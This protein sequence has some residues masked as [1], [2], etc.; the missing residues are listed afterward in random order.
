M[1]LKDFL[2]Y[3]FC[4]VS[5]ILFIRASIIPFFAVY[6]DPFDEIFM[7]IVSLSLIVTAFVITIKNGSHITG[8]IMMI[9]GG[10]YIWNGYRMLMTISEQFA[11]NSEAMPLINVNM[12]TIIIGTL[13]VG[14]GIFS[15]I[16]KMKTKKISTDKQ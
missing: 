1:H 6:G 10:F 13:L 15:I 5:I 11:E 9:I 8:S 16:K 14:L 3:G 12:Y 7:S 2:N 4:G